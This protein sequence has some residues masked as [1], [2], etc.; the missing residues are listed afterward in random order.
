LT[1]P[2]RLPPLPYEL[3]DMHRYAVPTYLGSRTLCH[4]SSAGCYADCNF[5]GINMVYEWRWMPEDAARTIAVAER[6]KREYGMNALEFFD[7][8][9]FP[10]ERR[11]MAIAEGLEPLG[12]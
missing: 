4:V 9:V 1:H 7:A 10:S 6:F 8:H 3:V 11:T 2:D 5:C 12:I